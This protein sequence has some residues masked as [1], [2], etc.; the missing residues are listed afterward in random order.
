MF[1]SYVLLIHILFVMILQYNL[2][3]D[4]NGGILLDWTNYL[5]LVACLNQTTRFRRS[6]PGYLSMYYEPSL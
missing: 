1:V 5:G 4:E 6:V 3:E 2:L